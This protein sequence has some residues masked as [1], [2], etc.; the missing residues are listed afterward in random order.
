M[1]QVIK[2]KMTTY[3]NNG[4]EFKSGEY[5]TYKSMRQAKEK[6]NLQYGAHLKAVVIEVL[7]DGT[8]Q[9]GLCLA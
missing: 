2:F 8:E 1:K 3:T 4:A 9:P 5:K 6:Q 7:E